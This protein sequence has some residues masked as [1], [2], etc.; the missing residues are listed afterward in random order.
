[1]N[2]TSK[3]KNQNWNEK[4]RAVTLVS[5]KEI[6]CLEKNLWFNKVYRTIEN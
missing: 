3:E 2:R 4:V 1:M 5:K 6:N